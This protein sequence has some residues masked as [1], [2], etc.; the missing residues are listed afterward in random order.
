MSKIYK[1]F[2]LN[3]DKQDLLFR[4]Y[5]E[6][7]FDFNNYH[8]VWEEECPPCMTDDNDMVNVDKIYMKFNMGNKPEGYKGHSLSVSDVVETNGRLYY[9]NSMGWKKLDIKAA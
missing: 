9:C 4:D 1:I 2:Q 7:T 8:K 3:E 6:S 5:K